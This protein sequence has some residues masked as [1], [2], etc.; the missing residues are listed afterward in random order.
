MTEILALGDSVE[1]RARGNKLV[2]TIKRI[3]LKKPRRRPPFEVA[4]IVPD[5]EISVW[6]VPTSSV[7]SVLG[8]G[9]LTAAI[10]AANAIQDSQRSRK[11]RMLINNTARQD[12]NGLN[13]MFEGSVI[14]IKYQ[15]VGFKRV[16]FLGFTGTGRV[17]FECPTTGKTR[18]CSPSICR[19]PA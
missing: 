12:S 18:S 8:K 2:G 19:K 4:E 14:E 6:T 13:G 1:F 5:G 9:N 11:R 10:Q 15:H 7:I 17:R 3:R 16:V